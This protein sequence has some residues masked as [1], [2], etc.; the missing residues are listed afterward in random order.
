MHAK[1]ETKNGLAI[2]DHTWKYYHFIDWEKTNIIGR[3]KGVRELQIKKLYIHN[4]YQ[5]INILLGI[6]GK[7]FLVVGSQLFCAQ[8]RQVASGNFYSLYS[9]EER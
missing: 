1:E 4:S 5:W 3:A 6:S 9:P 7:S 8:C 2:A